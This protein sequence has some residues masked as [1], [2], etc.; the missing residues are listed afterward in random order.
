MAINPIR[1]AVDYLRGNDLKVRTPSAPAQPATMAQAAAQQKLWLWN[2]PGSLF[3]SSMYGVE[4]PLVHG[5]LAWK[6]YGGVM[7]YPPIASNSAVFAC[8]AVIA[9]AHQEA[10]LR[11]FRT[12]REGKDEWVSDHPFQ[13]LVNDPHPSLTPVEV[14]WWLQVA[15]HVTGNGYLRK[16]RA[17]AGNVVELWPLSPTKVR[18]HTTDSDRRRGVFISHYRFEFE[19]SK[20]EEIPVGDIVHFRMGIDDRDHRLGLSPLQAIIREVSTDEEAHAFTEALLKNMG[21][22]GLVVTVPEPTRSPFTEEMAIALRERIDATFTKEG[23]GRTSVLTHGATMSQMGFDPQRMDLKNVH[24]VPEERVAAVLGVHPLVAGLGA[25]LDRSTF[26]NFEE[27]REGLFEQ[28]IMPLYAADAATWQKQLLRADFD[29]SQEVRCRYDTTDV[30]ALQDDQNKLYERLSLA[31]GGKPFLFR[32]EA[33]S[34]VGFD[35]VDGWDEED[36]QSALEAAQGMAELTAP[37]EES[38]SGPE[39]RMRRLLPTGERKAIGLGAF[40]GLLDAVQELAAPAL[41]RELAAYFREQG[42]RVQRRVRARG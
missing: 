15:K 9:K 23:R 35:P 3:T 17:G 8:L 22:V 10:P 18:P 42:Q 21:A 27:A 14:N 24:R 28:T 1:A 19:P 39:Q 13:A 6:L 34:E 26:S 12:S 7:G 40:P 32:N 16:I 31:V 2:H 37:E 33:R 4:G 36:Q 29:T 30:R 25:G 41:E 20:F 38:D 11:V 5:P